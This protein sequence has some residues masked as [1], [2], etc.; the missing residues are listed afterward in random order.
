MSC[1]NIFL[2]KIIAEDYKINIF[3]P[4]AKN[5][6]T[7]LYKCQRNED[8]VL[9]IFIIELFIHLQVRGSYIIQC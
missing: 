5:H 2:W 7:Y 6:K 3:L 4:L 9:P 8:I 1:N